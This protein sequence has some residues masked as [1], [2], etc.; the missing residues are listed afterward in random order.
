VSQS[1]KSARGFVPK[2]NKWFKLALRACASSSARAI[3]RQKARAFASA[4]SP[5][6]H[7]RR[8]EYEGEKRMRSASSKN[9]SAKSAGTAPR[10]VDEYLSRVPQP[11]R[12]TLRKIRAAIRSVMPP[13]ATETISYRIPAFAFKG[14]L[15]WYAAF[16]DHCSLFPTAAVIEKFKNELKG[17]VISKGTI[18]FPVDRPLPAT[19]IRKLAKA[20]IAQ[21]T[22]KKQR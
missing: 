14:P 18:Q 2:R 15:L 16:S 9:N 12:G 20:R 8:N 21:E 4:G 19:L 7:G 1:W 3:R 10:T 11:A 13:D 22:Q 6:A 17:Y 5:P